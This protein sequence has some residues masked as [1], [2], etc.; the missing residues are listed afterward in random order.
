MKKLLVLALLLTTLSFSPGPIYAQELTRADVE[1]R[2]PQLMSVLS[3]FGV[4]TSYI[5]A[6]TATE[7]QLFVQYSNLLR[8]LSLRLNSNPPPSAEE[9]ASLRNTL[10]EMQR[11]ISLSASWRASVNT[12]IINV[13]RILGNISNMI[14]SVV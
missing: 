10:T 13:T 5:Q 4:K 8:A 3:S 11:Q 2:I 6:R 12:T 7:N 9:M 1:A 14:A